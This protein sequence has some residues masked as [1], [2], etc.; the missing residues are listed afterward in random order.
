MWDIGDK[1]FPRELVIT[2]TVIATVM[3]VGVL[4]WW[5]PTWL[6]PAELT[7]GQERVLLLENELRRTGAQI[8]LGLLVLGTLYVT[9]RRAA[10]AE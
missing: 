2:A 5:V 10:A 9:W 6:T 3:V 1:R 4:L 8:A 7:V